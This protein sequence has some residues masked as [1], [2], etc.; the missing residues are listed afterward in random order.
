MFFEGLAASEEQKLAARL[1]EVAQRV[2]AVAR[3]R[4][5]Q[6]LAAPVEADVAA[7]T[8]ITAFTSKAAAERR[9][10]E[11]ASALASMLGFEPLTT[12]M[13][14]EGELRPLDGVAQA[15]AKYSAEAVA[16]RPEVLAA[17]AEA[18]AQ[19]RRAD[20]FRRSRVPSP[21]LSLFAQNDGFNERVFG[22]GISLPIPIPGNV[23]KTYIGEIA[24]AEALARKARTERE[25]F[26]RDIRLDVANAAHMFESS[27]RVVGLFST[28][29][30][31]RAEE[32]LLSLTGEVEGGRLALRDAIVSLQA[33]FDLLSADVE[34]RRTWCVASVELARSLGIVLEGRTH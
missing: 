5:D 25:R 15:L 10:K 32:T 29:Q 33:L 4:A 1:A 16:A 21:T 12:P 11:N 17:N 6:G 22:A 3:A 20:A 28:D 9:L 30:L 19:E 14:L 31:A 27:Q 8:T 18:R 23:G 34:A 26:E 13:T 24:E 2:S 7:A